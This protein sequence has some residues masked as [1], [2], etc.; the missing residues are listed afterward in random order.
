MRQVETLRP[1]MLADTDR[2]LWIDLVGKS[3]WSSPLLHPDFA[4]LMASCRS[5]VRIIRAEDRFG[6][7][8]FLPVHKRP[9]GL[10]RPIG[11]TF[12]DYHALIAEDGFSG[13]IEHMLNAARLRGFRYFNLIE[14]GAEDGHGHRF[15]FAPGTEPLKALNDAHP[16][17]AKAFRRLRRKLEREHGE[18]RLVLGDRSEATFEALLD[19]KDRQFARS[20]RHN[21]LRTRWARQ[22]IDCLRDGGEGD[23][24]PFQATLIANGQPVASEFGP[25][26]A[27]IFHPWI[28][29]FDPVYEA[30]SPG[31]LLVCE[32]LK[33]L[34]ESGLTIY[35]LGGGDDAHKTLFANETIGLSSGRAFAARPRLA[36]GLYQPGTGG[37]AGKIVRRWEQILLSETGV[38]ARIGGVA[39]A[40]RGL[41]ARKG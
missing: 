14:P 24:R 20:G 32:I 1:G 27:G 29:A 8:A 36:P 6:R 22:M 12:S 17:R 28:A 34:P 35:D 18:V 9:M 7:R 10:V 41:I 38:P 37:I 19:W 40:A 25:S 2:S 21:V 3:A 4:S 30:Y 15:R 26:W 13:T 31:H 16:K 33:G 11:S 5:D 39:S 23:I